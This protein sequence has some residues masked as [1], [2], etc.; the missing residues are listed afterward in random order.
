LSAKEEI[1]E[2]FT[3]S[4]SSRLSDNPDPVP[5]PDIDSPFASAQNRGDIPRAESF[6]Q[7]AGRRDVRGEELHHYAEDEEGLHAGRPFQPSEQITDVMATIAKEAELFVRQYPWQSL[8][9]GF[10]AGYLLAKSREK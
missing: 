4:G 10:A 3:N 2:S 1:V 7:A 5:S 9:L 6:D 8:L